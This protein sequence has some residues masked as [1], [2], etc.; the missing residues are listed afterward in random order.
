MPAGA[1]DGRVFA[2]M[3]LKEP[4]R[5]EPQMMSTLRLLASAMMVPSGLIER[6]AV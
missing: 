5:S 3:A 4:L 6:Q 1:S 2:T